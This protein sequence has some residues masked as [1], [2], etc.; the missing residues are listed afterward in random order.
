VVLVYG[1][2]PF[3]L[4][5][6]RPRLLLPSYRTTIRQVNNETPIPSFRE[7]TPR[8]FDAI[9]PL[10]ATNLALFVLLLL[11]A[12]VSVWCGVV[13]WLEAAESLDTPAI[14]VAIGSTLY[15]NARAPVRSM[16]RSP[17]YATRPAA[18]NN[19]HS[20][21]SWVQPRGTPSLSVP[22]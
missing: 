7:P 19:S 22:V 17:W 12:S 11:L 18:T 2:L 4:H 14:F 6:P 8:L 16:N 9:P 15:S 1:T 13:W 20:T 3:L 10:V 21:L 5:Q